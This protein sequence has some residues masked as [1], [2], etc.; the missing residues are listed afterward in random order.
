MSTFNFNGNSIFNICQTDEDNI[1]YFMRDNDFQSN[2]PMHLQINNDNYMPKIENA[3]DL[4]SQINSN[5]NFE[6]N[7][8]ISFDSNFE[9]DK[10]KK[11][12]DDDSL[13]GKRSCLNQESVCFFNLL[14]NNEN[15]NL[16]KTET[17]KNEIKKSNE[18][19]F[20]SLFDDELLKDN[21]I[22]RSNF[23]LK[24]V[25]TSDEP[26]T[27]LKIDDN[28]V[29][30]LNDSIELKQTERK[31]SPKKKK[32]VKF[33]EKKDKKI[34]EEDFQ[35]DNKYSEDELQRL[36]TFLRRQLFLTKI[37][38]KEEFDN[39]GLR[40]KKIL[41]LLLKKMYNKKRVM[42]KLDYKDFKKLRDSKIKKRNE[43]KNK[44]IY[45]QALKTFEK[46]FKVLLTNLK[47]KYKN[48]Y[49]KI[50]KNKK[51][52]FY[53]WL[54]KKTIESNN[55]MIDIIMDIFY[56]KS[57]AKKEAIEENQNW[58]SDRDNKPSAIKKI[59]SSI[60]HLIRK[61]SDCKNKFISLMS[62]ED[63]KGLIKCFRDDI[64]KKLD[65]KLN[66]WLENLKKND[67][68][69]EKF[70]EF[71]KNTIQSR[72]YKN[73]WTIQSIEEAITYCIDELENDSLG[74]LKHEYDL[75]KNRHYSFRRS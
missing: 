24:K 75:I 7:S 11:F 16:L 12:F 3:I 70:V 44:K 48:S 62:F 31:K 64:E 45:K 4:I 14:T 59:S 29:E 26:V 68:S 28:S 18:N 54:L 33:S 2:P 46:E 66:F 20:T 39:L 61:D 9:N 8:I 35:D 19:V 53:F 71:F 52:S 51:S 10:S 60:K 72:Q 41:Y 69:F 17:E 15:I 22:L 38:D 58:S 63:N 5:F 42:T 47:K 43:E 6:S 27:D 67:Y 55:N 30:D 13:L 32:L 37:D 73:P 57:V 74:S 34:K 23:N 21:I 50:F 36:F 25:K 65:V 56:E 49:P 1:S 40:N